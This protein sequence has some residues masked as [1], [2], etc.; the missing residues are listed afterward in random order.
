MLTIQFRQLHMSNA[1]F[2][3]KTHV[4]GELPYSLVNR[5]TVYSNTRLRLQSCPIDL[6][7]VYIHQS[8][9][10]ELLICRDYE[11]VTS[12]GMYDCTGLHTGQTLKI[13][14]MTSHRLV[15]FV[16]HFYFIHYHKKND[17]QFL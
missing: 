14:F 8:I 2:F 12:S 5:S 16:G 17:G 13:T 1:F 10:F 3:N 11:F 6:I 7:D 4:V 9:L 15:D